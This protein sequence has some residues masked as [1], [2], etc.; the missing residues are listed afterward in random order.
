MPNSLREGACGL[1]ALGGLRGRRGNQVV[2]HDH[3]LRRIG[4]LQHPAPAFRQEGQIDQ[5][6]GLHIDH[7]DITRRDLRQPAGARKDLLGDRHA[8]PCGPP[9]NIA[10]IV[11]G[12]GVLSRDR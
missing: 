11:A 3:H 8:H 5:A 7:D 6:R 10:G 1:H 9:T 12:L 4:D 2:E